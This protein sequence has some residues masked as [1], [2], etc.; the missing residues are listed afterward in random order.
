MKQNREHKQNRKV[1]KKKRHIGKK[2]LTAFLIILLITVAAGSGVLIAVIKSAP[3]IN[4]DILDNLKQS[5]KIY[6]KEGNFIEDLSDAENRQV[7]PL[8]QI[9]ENLKNA[10]ISIEDERFEYHHGIDVQRIFGA[11]V[12]DI[13]TMSKAQGASTITQQLIKNTVL[14]P[15]KKFTRKLQEMYLAMQLERKLSK[16]QI[17]HAYLNTIYLGGNAYGVQAASLYYFG[18]NVKDLDLAECALIAG[19]TQN[20]AKYWPYSK[21]NRENPENYLQRQ[22]LVLS[23]MLKLGKITKEEY[24][25]ALNEKLDFKT[26]EAEVATKYQWFIEP[27]ID[28]VAKDFSQKYGISESEARQKLR[29]GGY[30]IYLTI[31]AKIQEKAESVI[32]DPKYYPKISKKDMYYSINSKDK[33]LIQP[34]AAAVIMDSTTGEVRAIVGGRGPHPLKSNNR[35][36]DTDVARQPGSAIK[37]LSV[38]APALEKK[39]ITAATTVEDS[40]MPQDFVNSNHWDPKNY[41]G[42]FG[43]TTTIRNA[44]K[45]S[46]NLVAIKV[47]QDLGINTSVDFL[48]NKFHIS[49][50]Q[51]EGGR[52][53]KNL[54][55]L[56]LGG[57]TNG[58]TPLEMAAAYSVFANNGIYSEPIMYTKVEDNKK[59]VILEKNSNQSKAISPQAAYIMNDMLQT[60]V[61]S[62]TGTKARLG[63]MP[64]GGK[65][66]TSDDHTNGYFMGI[67]PYYT[68]AVWMGHDDKNYHVPGLVGGTEAPMWH[69]I[70]AVAHEGLQVKSFT[71][72]S[73]IVTAQVCADSGKAP[74]DLCAQDPRGSRVRTEIFIEGTQP[75]ELC[76]LHVAVDIDVSTGKLA[77]P[78]CPPELVQKKVFINRAKNPRAASGDDA[79]IVPTEYCTIHTGEQINNPGSIDGNNPG[80]PDNIDGNNPGN[81]DNGNNPGDTGGT[82]NTNTNDPSGDTNKPPHQDHN[83]P[84]DKPK[85][86]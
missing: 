82:D 15:E 25:Q 43:G 13:K 56:S 5:G 53:D 23:Q 69:D 11:I 37:P 61:K 47:L 70:M 85:K 71:K 1:R 63:S 32:N 29:T 34:Q 72:P 78:N 59:T 28:Q 54:S 80:G 31:D 12:Y 45:D 65:T 20:P 22:R 79:Y 2:I 8:S 66:G 36:T 9:P 10:V 51:T 33:E 73:G 14:T 17:L 68:G 3:P 74:T 77:T 46:V 19:L 67:T 35:A 18:E 21:K 38:Y 62:G 75:I 7:V 57:L 64:V 83:N 6:D 48:K 55:S 24:D 81:I 4:A 42:R 40:P 44:V 86:P 52:N 41:N 60:V 16:D 39:V 26:K 49:T 30:S 84:K 58:V 50:I 76:D 27:A